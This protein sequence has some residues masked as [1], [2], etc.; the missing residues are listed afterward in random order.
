MNMQQTELNFSGPQLAL[1]GQQ[2]AIDTA[3]SK[4]PG[5]SDKAYR[6]LIDYVKCYGSQPFKGEDARH[7]SMEMG[8]PAPPSLR[9]FG[10]IIS[11]ASREGIIKAVGYTQ[12][13]N[14]KAH[15]AN[16][17]LWIRA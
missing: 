12:V 16:C 3:N 15:A 17:R 2:L 5:W 9:A 11:K 10:A 1:I 8:L 7:W 4:E 13:T 6:L 14:K